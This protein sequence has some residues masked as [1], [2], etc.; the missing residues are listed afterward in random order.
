MCRYAPDILT[1]R[2]P[3]MNTDNIEYTFGRPLS[4]Y[5]GNELQRARLLILKSRIADMHRAPLA[6]WEDSYGSGFKSAEVI[7]ALESVT[8]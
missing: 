2:M 1:E 6:I 8:L 7:N 5:V 3:T 4:T